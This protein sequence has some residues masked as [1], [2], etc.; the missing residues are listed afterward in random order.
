[1]KMIMTPK[2]KGVSLICARICYDKYRVA[3]DYE[4]PIRRTIG[5]KSKADDYIRNQIAMY[6]KAEGFDTEDEYYEDTPQYK[7]DVQT[8][9]YFYKIW[10][11]IENET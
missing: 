2:E 5:W 11:Q 3:L 10:M 4:T 9:E 8:I 7:H 1:M 6:R